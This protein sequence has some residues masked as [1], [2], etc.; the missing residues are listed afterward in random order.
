[1][2][3]GNI[4]IDD[5]VALIYARLNQEIEIV[6][7]VA[8]YG[9]VSRED[10]VSNIYYVMKLFDFKEIPV[11]L[12][13]EVPLTGEQPTYYPEIHGERGLGPIVPNEDSEIKIEN[14]WE[15]IKIIE[16]YKDELIIVNIGRLTSLATMFFLYHK[17]MKNVK[18]IYMMGGAFWVPGNVT[19]VAEANFHGDPFAVNIVLTYATNVTIILLNAT[20]KAIVTPGMVDYI[21]SFGKTKIFKPLMQYYTR[22]YQERD[23]S[24]LGSPVHDALTLMATIYPNMFSLL[25]EVSI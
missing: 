19:T 22:F 15:I 14:F 7:L 9:N 1:M 17:L 18:E 13:A 25:K 20:Q 12:G 5:T 24:L 8:D 6:G 16:K 2:F 4:G 10:A 23:P 21:D 11:I 3:F